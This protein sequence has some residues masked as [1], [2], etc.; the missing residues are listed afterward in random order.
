MAYT[1]PFFAECRAYGRMMEAQEKGVLKREVVVPCHGY[2]LLQDQDVRFLE[3]EG[4]D[5]QLDVLADELCQAAGGGGRVRA[6]VKDLVLEDT[7]VNRRSLGKILR[8]IRTL[9]RLG[10]Y[11][12][13]I[14]AE[15]FKGGRLVDFGS[16]WTEPHCILSA[17]DEEEARDSRLEDLVRF[18]EMVTEEGITTDVRA[19]PNLDYCQKLRSW[20]R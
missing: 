11:N 1:D 7:G 13:D 3:G 18:D 10:I 15:N 6:I 8:N 17:L 14:R 12:K 4:I 2:L 19:M 16:S 9:N 5:L 20:V